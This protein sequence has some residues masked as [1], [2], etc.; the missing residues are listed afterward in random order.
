[1]YLSSHYLGGLGEFRLLEQ[2]AR[3]VFLIWNRGSLL[4]QVHPYSIFPIQVSLRC[5]VYD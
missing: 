3:S 2:I 4:L 5:T 1:M